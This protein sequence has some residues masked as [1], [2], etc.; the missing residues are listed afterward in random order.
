MYYLNIAISLFSQLQFFNT[1][2]L[3]EVPCTLCNPALFCLCSYTLRYKK[4]VWPM[5]SWAQLKNNVPPEEAMTGH[6]FNPS[7][8]LLV[9]WSTL[10][11]H[12]SI[13]ILQYCI[14]LSFLRCKHSKLQSSDSLS[15]S[16]SVT[17]AWTCLDKNAFWCSDLSRWPMHLLL[18]TMEG[19]YKL[20]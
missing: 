4:G 12:H 20:W 18:L 16:E 9:P 19:S 10:P 7:A 15:V 3:H 13:C 14:T 1:C 2:T 17:F 8:Y 6:S 5:E 11:H